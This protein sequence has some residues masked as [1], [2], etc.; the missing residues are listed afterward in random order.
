MVLAQRV[1]SNSITFCLSCLTLAL[2]YKEVEGTMSS[3]SLGTVVYR[4]GEKEEHGGGWVS[5]WVRMVDAGA[6][7]SG[8]FILGPLCF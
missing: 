4:V 1:S 6:W 2:A 5:G 8:M 3:V 7:A